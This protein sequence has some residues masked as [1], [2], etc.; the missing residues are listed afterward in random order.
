MTVSPIAAIVTR[1]AA[2][3][4]ILSARPDAPVV[5]EPGAPVPAPRLAG[6][7]RTL[8]SV[9]HHAADLVAPTAYGP[10]A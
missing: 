6:S 9:L 3:R 4:T 10:A 8:S 7:R 2:E 5:P 1:Q